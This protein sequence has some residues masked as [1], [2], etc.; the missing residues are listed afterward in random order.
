[1]RLYTNGS[2]RLGERRKNLRPTAAGK[3]LIVRPATDGDGRRTCVNERTRA[4]EIYKYAS[5]RENIVLRITKDVP[6]GRPPHILSQR[7][8][9]PP[10][11]P[12]PSTPSTPPTP[13][14]TP[15]QP[16]KS[17]HACMDYQ[18]AARGL[19]TS[20]WRNAAMRWVRDACGDA[21]RR[22]ATQTGK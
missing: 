8:P 2:P 17:R 12:T 10:T 19:F 4:D 14:P 22:D 9:L 11:P 6:A 16:L 1:M 7:T 18:E 13:P 3:F 21:T 5:C 15:T 20:G